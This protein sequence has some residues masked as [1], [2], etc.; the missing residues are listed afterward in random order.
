MQS[1]TAKLDIDW[2]SLNI[3]SMKSYAGRDF[4]ILKICLSLMEYFWLMMEE[5]LS[6][7]DEDKKIEKGYKHYCD[8]MKSGMCDMIPI[9]RHWLLFMCLFLTRRRISARKC[10][11]RLIII[12][13]K[14]AEEEI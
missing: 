5:I 3:V 7:V 12:C 1:V 13:N 8:L 14:Q 9:R 2:K 6:L 11:L 4:Y 10:K